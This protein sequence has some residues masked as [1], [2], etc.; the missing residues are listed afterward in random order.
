M[1][2]QVGGELTSVGQHLIEFAVK[3]LHQLLSPLLEFSI[4]AAA[5]AEIAD[6]EAV[7]ELATR[8]ELGDEG[9]DL[10]RIEGESRCHEG[11]R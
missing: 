8:I 4:T 10:A 11:A 3:A 1:T 9:V 2:R 6:G 5:V 7:D